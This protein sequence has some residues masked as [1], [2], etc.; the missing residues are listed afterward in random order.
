MISLPSSLFRL[1]LVCCALGLLLCAQGA[2]ALATSTTLISRGFGGGPA[3]TDAETRQ[4]AVSDDGRFV[5]FLS[6]STSY[7]GNPEGRTQVFLRDRQTGQVTLVSR[8]SNGIPANRDC[9]RLAMSRDGRFV[10]FASDAVNLEGALFYPATAVYLR[11]LQLGKTELVSQSNLAAQ[12]SGKSGVE[13]LAISADGRFVAFTSDASSLV[14]DDANAAMDVF[15][16]DRETGLTERV[17]QGRFLAEANSRSGYDGV[18][19]SDDGRFVTFSSFASNLVA[20]D[21]NNQSD[22]FVRDRWQRTTERASIADDG[23]EGLGASGSPSI[24]AD[25]SRVAFIS[26][27]PDL[28]PGDNNLVQDAFVRD[29]L[30][31]RTWRVSVN[32]DG[33]ERREWSAIAT[34]S[35]D[36]GVVAFWRGVAPGP[37]REGFDRHNTY[38]DVFTHEL[39][40]GVTELVSTGQDGNPSS[41]ATAFPTPPSL[42]SGGRFVA[43]VC[44]A[45]N[46]AAG[47]TNLQDDA[48]LRDRLNHRTDWISVGTDGSPALAGASST[49]AAITPDGRFVAFTSDATNLVP[50]DTNGVPDVFVWDRQSGVIE[51]VSVASDGIQGD[52]RSGEM[53]GAAAGP[54]ISADGR[55]V[56]FASAA[57]NLV[58]N[59]RNLWN[60]TFVRDR[61]LGITERVSVGNDGSELLYG[62]QGGRPALSADGR[63]VAFASYGNGPADGPLVRTQILIRDRVDGT[64][65]RV[66]RGLGGAWTDGDSFDP[67]LSGDGRFVAFSSLASNLVT[68]DYNGALDIFVYDRQAGTTE[69]VNL[70]SNGEVANDDCYQTRISADGRYVLFLSSASNLVAQDRNESTDAFVR[71]RSGAT[72]VCASL[73]LW[74]YVGNAGAQRAA[75]SPDGRF[76]ALTSIES[77]LPD[78]FLRDLDRNFTERVGVSTDGVVGNWR[79]TE[80]LYIAPAVSRGGRYIAFSSDA[81]NLVSDDTNGGRDLFLRDRSDEAL[82]SPSHLT[83]S[84]VT[85]DHISLRWTDES[86]NEDYFQIERREGDG[87]FHFVSSAPRNSQQFEQYGASPPGPYTYRVRAVNWAV[88]SGYSNEAIVT[89][90]ELP[91]TPFGLTVTPKW[92]ISMGLAWS[93]GSENTTGFVVERSFNA[94]GPFTP[95]RG[96]S[97]PAYTDVSVTGSTT[98]YYRVAATNPRGRSDY[99]EVVSATT[100][101]HLPS[102]PFNL[103]VT[104]VGQDWI[105]LGWDDFGT[106]EDGYRIERRLQGGTF[107]AVGEA[108]VNQ[109]TFI[110][111]NLPP[112]TRFEY[113]VISF[114]RSGEAASAVVEGT[115]LPISGGKLRFPHHIDFGK[116]PD[117]TSRTRKVRFQNQSTTESLHVNLDTPGAP[118][119]I[120]AADR[121]FAIPPR[122]SHTVAVTCRGA[123]RVRTTIRWKGQSGDPKGRFFEIRLSA[124]SKRAVKRK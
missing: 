3:Q 120:E 67:A 15:V 6:N 115:T 107:A 84:L 32:S 55:Y 24:S 112:S 117:Q 68:G 82:P 101:P 96:V 31:R 47:D 12:P 18:G 111:R 79:S 77:G 2:R 33:S 40:T 16:R 35:P 114:N 34:I 13:G 99:S 105:A 75:L 71:D 91:A 103:R 7:G 38:A 14:A 19:I 59:D 80:G 22:V 44:L 108:G 124:E 122:S 61:L 41:L 52:A 46:L 5:A 20:G 78:V 72:T 30:Q 69:R 118:F 93:S 94:T 89:Y 116:V 51:R 97:A 98:Y 109:S 37:L 121:S 48:F 36:G 104:Q 90:P 4:A 10:A 29:R 66:S 57:T 76:V 9:F 65:E 11:D 49:Q 86:S 43:W 102:V 74:N 54:E 27:A 100:L 8:S 85:G 39:A 56:A 119:S 60:D 113:R 28:V 95:V 63:F 23:S 64:T 70:N 62:S 53:G 50:V 25:G 81:S 87:P 88:T 110:D 58:P 45:E 73:S 26:S 1:L 92:P 106:V 17:S 21:N 83:A 42:S 123:D